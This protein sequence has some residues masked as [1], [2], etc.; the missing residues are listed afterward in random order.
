MF[1]NLH[2][3]FPEKIVPYATEFN[4]GAFLDDDELSSNVISFLVGI[5]RQYGRYRNPEVSDPDPQG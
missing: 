4:T 3:L 1:D 5:V 2:L